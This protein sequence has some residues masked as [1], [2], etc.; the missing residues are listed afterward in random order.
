[1]T[2]ELIPILIVAGFA[3]IWFEIFVPGMILATAGTLC[4]VASV[5][6]TYR[7]YG[8]LLCVALSA[9]EALAFV[10]V[11]SRWVKWF[12]H[13]KMGRSIILHSTTGTAAQVENRDSLLQQT[14]TVISTCRPAGIAE[15]AKERYDVIS[16]GAFLAAGQTVKVVAIEGNKIIVRA[17]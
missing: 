17:V 10:V 6:V 15:F 4:L 7:L 16:E 9:F 12:P 13:T 2:W 5:V 14:G 3:L 11:A 1:M 8:P